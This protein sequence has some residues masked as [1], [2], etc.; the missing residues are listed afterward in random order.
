MRVMVVE[1]RRRRRR[2]KKEYQIEN[3]TPR[4]ASFGVTA[5]LVAEPIRVKAKTIPIAKA[6]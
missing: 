2:K 3:G 4:L 1:E 5:K 6:N